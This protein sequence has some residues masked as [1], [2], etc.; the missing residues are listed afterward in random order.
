MGRG[1]SLT[2][3]HKLSFD[4]QMRL[5]PRHQ[6]K[7]I[8]LKPLRSSTQAFKYTHTHHLGGIDLNR[9]GPDRTARRALFVPQQTI[10]GNWKL[11]TLILKLHYNQFHF[12]F[13]FHSRRPLLTAGAGP[14]CK[15]PTISWPSVWKLFYGPH[16]TCEREARDDVWNHFPHAG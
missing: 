8:Y 2:V 7:V 5:R 14:R 16:M 9:M 15:T 1:F 10:T 13:P 11:G 4:S 3:R 6:R 12:Y